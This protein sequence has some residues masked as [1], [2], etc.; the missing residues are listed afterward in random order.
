MVLLALLRDPSRLH[1]GLHSAG[2]AVGRAGHVRVDPDPV[3]P[4]L[5]R[6]LARPFG[7]VPAGV[8]AFLLAADRGHPDPRL[9]RWRRG[10]S[11][12]RRDQPAG[13]GILF[14]TLPHHPA[15]DLGIRTAASAA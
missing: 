7:I 12:L 1:G 14:R 10:D 11:N 3:L 5:A 8:Q 6:P 15:A 4:A 13:S 2:E 9:V